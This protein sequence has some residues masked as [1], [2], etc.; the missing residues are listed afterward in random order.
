MIINTSSLKSEIKAFKKYKLCNSKIKRGST[1]KI[2]STT[3]L[4]IHIQT[5]H[6]INQHK[7]KEEFKTINLILNLTRVPK[8]VPKQRKF[9]ALEN[10]VNILC[11][12]IF[13]QNNYSVS[14]I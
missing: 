14:M 9:R 3:P 8:S 2:Y 11:F 12:N 7:S 4:H 1:Q 13:Q 5:K 6:N 10:R